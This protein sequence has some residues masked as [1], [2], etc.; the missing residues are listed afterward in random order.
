MNDQELVVDGILSLFTVAAV[1]FQS[2]PLFKIPMNLILL[3]IIILAGTLALI[4]FHI[5]TRVAL[6]PVLVCSFG[7]W[8]SSLVGI[9]DARVSVSTTLLILSLALIF[10]PAVVAA[11]RSGPT[12]LSED[13]RELI[14][15][16]MAAIQRAVEETAGKLGG[17]VTVSLLQ[18]DLQSIGPPFNRIDLAGFRYILDGF[19]DADE[20]TRV[21]AGKQFWIYDFPSVRANLAQ[22]DRLIVENLRDNPD[23]LGR[24]ELLL[25]TRLS[26]ESLD[27]SLT[28]LE[29]KV[30]IRKMDLIY[31]LTTYA[32]V[33]NKSP[34]K[35]KP[36]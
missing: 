2:I 22:A 30:L 16:H 29:Q 6:M 8:A 28:R 7:I 35:N 9:V 32:G 25:K 21:Y 13:Q 10:A 15:E 23:G 4:A 17:I 33:I 24:E 5:A 27:A 20:A 14:E 34:S 19:A 26:V 18:H 31:K 11:V 36:S 1:S 12:V 3:P